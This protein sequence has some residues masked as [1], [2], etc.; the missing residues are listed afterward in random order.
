M[1]TRGH[2]QALWETESGLSLPSEVRV[3]ARGAA[4]SL[5]AGLSSQA[6]GYQ[7]AAA[8]SAVSASGLRC[9]LAF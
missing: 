4:S 3:L 7:A 1:L 6:G 5:R 2:A 9:L 8:E